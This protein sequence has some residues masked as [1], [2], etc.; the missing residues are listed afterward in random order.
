MDGI[1]NKFA[2]TLPTNLK[3]MLSLK[4]GVKSLSRL[5]VPSMIDD[6]GRL[7][8]RL[9]SDQIFIEVFDKKSCKSSPNIW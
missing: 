6:F 4:R 8:S 5:F 3:G 1:G 7:F 2:S 9:Q